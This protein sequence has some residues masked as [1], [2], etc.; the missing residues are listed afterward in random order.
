MPYFLLMDSSFWFA[1]INLGCSIVYI[2]VSQVII[3]KSNFISF[4][5]DFFVL[6]NSLDPDEMPC[7]MPFHLGLH[8][9]G[10]VH[11]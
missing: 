11:I 10:K 6:A 1:T 7:Y 2:G 3:S 4:S 8:G 9:F 5:E